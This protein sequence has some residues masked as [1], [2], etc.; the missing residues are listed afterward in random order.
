MTNSENPY[1][2]IGT[3]IYKV[4]NQP[5]ASGDKCRI[6]KKWSRQ[7]I[8]DDNAKNWQSIINNM[9]KYDGFCFIPNHVS[10]QREI[11]G[12]Y[13]QYEGISYQPEKGDWDLINLF[14]NHIFGEQY[15]TGLDYI[16]LIY[17]KPTQIL[18]ILCLVSTERNTGKTTFLNLL[19]AIFENNMTINTNEDFRNNFNSGWISKVII[20][21]DE[22]LL[23]RKEDAERIKNLSTTRLAKSEA[24]GKDKIETQF[25]GKFILCSNN[26]RNFI[27]IDKS[28]I[29]Y[30]VRKVPKFKV[31]DPSLL[32]KMIKQIPA[33]LFFLL[34]RKMK[35]KQKTRMW[36]EPNELHTEALEVLK[37]NSRSTTEKNLLLMLNEIYAG[38]HN[39]LNGALYYT[40]K[41]LRV[42]YKEWNNKIVDATEIF[43]ILKNSWNLQPKDSNHYYR[44]TLHGENVKDKG[45]YY[46]IEKSIF[47]NAE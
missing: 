33:F 47:E 16:Q 4:V 31:E 28:E 37:N 46:T 6:I 20:G 12:F 32:E 7:N 23:D 38:A 41:D 40:A 36:F 34:H 2:R 35:S 19:K 18:P 30:W 14:L 22:V 11:E 5:L 15:E 27:K 3:E 1:L 39:E 24:K 26:E 13:N 21:V 43:T 44:T 9:P 8:K 45:R 25:F 10:Y 17:L 29:R 42:L